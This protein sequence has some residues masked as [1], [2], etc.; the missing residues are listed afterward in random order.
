MNVKFQYFALIVSFF[1]HIDFSFALVL[2]RIFLEGFRH[3]EF[4]ERLGRELSH[5]LAVVRN[6]NISRQ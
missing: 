1:F 5:L 4:P 6:L 3:K 2:L